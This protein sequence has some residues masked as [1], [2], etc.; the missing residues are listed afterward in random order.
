MPS[1]L[2]IHSADVAHEIATASSFGVEIQSPPKVNG[3][4]VLERVR[5][6]RDR[7]VGFVLDSVDD[8][9]RIEAGAIVVAAGS[10]RPTS[11]SV[12]SAT[13]IRDAPG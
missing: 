4:A 2:L 13:T 12:K 9:T 10:I 11:R 3:K 5:R 1:K 7:F 8:H 6:A